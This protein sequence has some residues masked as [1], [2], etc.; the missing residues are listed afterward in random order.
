MT[1]R[2]HSPENAIRARQRTFIN[3]AQTLI[4]AGTSQ[5]RYVQSLYQL[6]LNRQG[7]T[8][9]VAYWTDV[10]TSQSQSFVAQS[11]L[12]SQENRSISIGEYYTSLLHRPADAASLN[13]WL[14]SNMD[15]ASIRADFESTTEF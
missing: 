8:S 14:D 11:F 2:Q 3:D 4:S 6:L 7:S 13:F 1:I 9:D 5:Q 15:F 10:L 12:T